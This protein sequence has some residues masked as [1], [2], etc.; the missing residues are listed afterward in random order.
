MATLPTEYLTHH[1]MCLDLD[2]MDHHH[3]V[4]CAEDRLDAADAVLMRTCH[5]LHRKVPKAGT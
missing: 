1:E 4:A 3:A 2:E 5:G